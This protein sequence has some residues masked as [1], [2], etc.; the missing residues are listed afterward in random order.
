MT[1]QLLNW[2]KTSTSEEWLELAKK[3]GTTIGYLNLVAY[4]YRNAS[5]RLASSIEMAS[6]SFDGKMMIKKENLVFRN[7]SHDHA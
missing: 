5:P 7:S 4:G 3:A 6:Q 1:N 2:R